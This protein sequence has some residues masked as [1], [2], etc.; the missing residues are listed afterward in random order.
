MIYKNKAGQKIHVFAYDATTGAPKTGDAAQITGYV[1]L[2]GVANAID[3]TNPAEVD[4]TNMPG[5]YVFDLTQAETDCD[6]FAVYAK[7]STENIRI[8]PIISMAHI[9]LSAGVGA[10][11]FAYRVTEASTGAPVPAVS[12]RV[13]SDISGTTTVASGV[14]D[15]D[16]TVIFALD[17]G[18]YYFW[19]TKTGWTFTDPDTEVVA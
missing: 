18:T 4:S 11:N 12:V 2:D 13:S 6:A 10:I 3:D 16:G 14:T 5:L 15:V 17:A 19:R 8:D 7:S 9:W 1:G